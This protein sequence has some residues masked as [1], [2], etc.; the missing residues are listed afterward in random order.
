MVRLL[1]FHAL[2]IE[3]ADGASGVAIERIVILNALYAGDYLLIP[4]ICLGEVCLLLFQIIF[5]KIDM[6]HV[7]GRLTGQVV[8]NFLVENWPT[9]E[10]K[11]CR[12]LHIID[13]LV[14]IFI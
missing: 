4:S 13:S 14:D 6:I 10:V 9:H 12:L 5:Y 3:V 8:V 1:H 2:K 11:P 7:V